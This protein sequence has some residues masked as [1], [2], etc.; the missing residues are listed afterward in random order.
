LVGERGECV[1]NWSTRQGHPVGV[2]VAYIY[3]NGRFWTNCNAHRKRVAA[4]RSR[5]Q[6]SVV[7]NTDGRSATFKGEAVI[8]APGDDD[9]DRLTG[10]FYPALA[11]TERDPDD[12]AARN[13]QKFLNSPHQVIIETPADLL[14]S[15][16][17]AKFG[18][19]MQ[20]AIEAGLRE[21]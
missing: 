13:H 4:L 17:F 2:V 21:D 5:P 11:G 15:F 7:V 18:A 14:V 9:W 16:D 1:L 3:R 8:H 20:A 6:S 12:P 10:W 19:V